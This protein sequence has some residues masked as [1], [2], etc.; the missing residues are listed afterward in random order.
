MTLRECIPFG[1]IDDCPGN[2]LYVDTLV[3]ERL[4]SDGRILQR[5]LLVFHR[6]LF[7][8]R[9]FVSCPQD[10]FTGD[11]RIFP[12]IW[13]NVCLITVYGLPGVQPNGLQRYLCAGAFPTIQSAGLKIETDTDVYFLFCFGCHDYGKIN[14]K[15]F[16]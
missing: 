6:S 5:T 9:L 2:G 13:R 12:V 16:L 10:L 15:E 3:P 11:T 8:P 14:I 4:H 7:V 1:E